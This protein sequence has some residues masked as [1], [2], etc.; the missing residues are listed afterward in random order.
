MLNN[1][2]E[3]LT[4]FKV[5]KQIKVFSLC[6][7][8]LDVYGMRAS[9]SS[10]GPNYWLWSGGNVWRIIQL[11]MWTN[12]KT[13]SAKCKSLRVKM[14]A[15]PLNPAASCSQLFLWPSW[16]FVCSRRNL[17]LISGRETW[18]KDI[19][20]LFLRR[21]LWHFSDVLVPQLDPQH[22]FLI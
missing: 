7:P 3:D 1:I 10:S 21:L 12:R 16:G 19:V 4:L 18:G 5:Q 22:V 14:C 20:L 17:R 8:L 13:K 2:A 11:C 15:A 6:S 9:S